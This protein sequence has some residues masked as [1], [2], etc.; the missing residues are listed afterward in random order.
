MQQEIANFVF[1]NPVKIV[2]G[3]NRIPELASLIPDGKKVLITYGGG[4]VKRF[5]TLDRVKEA[6]KD[7]E[8]GEFG[9]IEA[10][11]TY[12]TCIEA[13][14]KIKAE[15]YDYLLAVGGGSV[16]DGTKFI[17]A[18]AEF[19]GNPIDIFGKGLGKG[20]AIEKALPF[21]T[22][23]T[24]PATSS[25]M[26]ETSVISFKEKSAKVSFSHPAVF[27]QFSIL[28]P[29]LTYTLPKRQ[30]ANGV[31]DAFIHII[32]QYLT[33][34]VGGMVQDRFAESLLQILIEIG[35]DVVDEDNH[36]YNLRANFMWTATIALNRLLSKGVPGDWATHSLG[37]QITVLNSTDHA[38]SLT[39]VLPALMHVRRKEKHDKLIQY[40]ERVWGITEGTDEE[41]I[42]A[43]ISRTTDFFHS[44]D[45]PVSLREVGV[46]ESD[47]D[48]LVSQL[49]RHETDRIGEDG[50]QTL[51]TSREIYLTALTN[52]FL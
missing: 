35:P 27:P 16:I 28:E 15:G 42:N 37:H 51:E 20:L 9:G 49:E 18:A 17:A 29:E 8:Y 7:F 12:E 2:F 45:M 4:S 32:E 39:A 25:E 50:V 41:K 47:I 6:L 46:D 43:A 40:A 19:D 5:G 31:S 44:L 22:V 23:L 14:E 26:N 52:D 30:L 48:Q 24:L 1:Y 10:N 33:Y 13:V 3:K 21:G 11:P 36:D 38:R 34:P